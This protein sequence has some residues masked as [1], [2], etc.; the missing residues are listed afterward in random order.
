MATTGKAATAA[1]QESIDALVK[2]IEENL[3]AGTGDAV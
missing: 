1:M 2:C 3:P